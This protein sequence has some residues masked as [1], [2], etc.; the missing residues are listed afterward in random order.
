MSF[1]IKEMVKTKLKQLTVKEMLYHA[2]QYGFSLTKDEATEIIHYI[3][4][5]DIDIFSKKGIDDAHDKIAA[6]TNPQTAHKAR[7]LFEQLIKAYGLEHLF[8]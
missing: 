8:Q 4:T 2:D 5:N 3:Q 6:I 1:F 7:G